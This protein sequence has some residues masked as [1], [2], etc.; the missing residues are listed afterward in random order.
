MAPIQPK[1]W[2]SFCRIGR[3]DEL[4]EGAAGVDD[5][6]RRAARL[7]RQALAR[8]ADQHREAA[9]AGT[10]RRQQAERDD[11]AEGAVMNG[12]SALPRASSSKPPISTRRR[13]VA[14]GDGAGDRLHGAPGELADG[15]RQADRGDAEAGAGVERR[16]EE[17]ERL[18]GAHGDHQDAGGRERDGP[19]RQVVEGTEHA[20]C[21]C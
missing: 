16:D 7:E 15:Q 2:I 10:D 9:G 13:P 12:V 3:E 11:Q 20:A 21:R 14:V 18:A 1:V 8:G 5:A 19:E 6:R 4:A 17:A